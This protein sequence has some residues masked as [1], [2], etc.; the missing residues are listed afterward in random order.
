MS[1]PSS[2]DGNATVSYF[3][4]S[5][6]LGTREVYCCGYAS[7]DGKRH[8]AY[9]PHTAY[10]CPHCGEVWARAVYDHHFAYSPIPAASWVVESRRCP[11]HGDGYLLSGCNSLQLSTCSREL[12]AREALLLC[13]HHKEPFV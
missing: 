11:S 1:S 2:P 12:L 7:T 8:S 13:L 10:F 3:E 9:W 5:Q 6:F 4:G